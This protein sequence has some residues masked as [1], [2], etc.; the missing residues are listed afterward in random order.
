MHITPPSPNKDY[1][2]ILKT[3]ILRICKILSNNRIDGIIDGIYAQ[4]QLGLVSE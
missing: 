4:R 1:W 3:F 2:L